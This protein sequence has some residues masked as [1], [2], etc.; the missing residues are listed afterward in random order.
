MKICIVGSGWCLISFTTSLPATLSN[1]SIC[2]WTVT[3]K[4]GMFNVIL[5]F[6]FDV[7][8]SA[9]WTRK[10][11][12]ALGVACQ[13]LTSGLTGRIASWPFKGSRIIPEKK[14]EAA[15]LGLP[16]LTQIVGYLLDTPSIIFFLE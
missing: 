9:A 1:A 10:P 12:A 13:C 2:S 5:S 3:D 6:N 16:G 14:P 8:I 11:A 7:S 15:R 4:P